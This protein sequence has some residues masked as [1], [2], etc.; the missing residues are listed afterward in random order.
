MQYTTPKGNKMIFVGYDKADK[1]VAKH[2][3][4]GVNVNW[5]GWDMVFFKEDRRAHRSKNGRRHGDAW[6][7]E[8]V[9]SP[10]ANGKWAVSPHLLRGV[11]A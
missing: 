2:Q 10:N 5:R 11:N 7:F 1:F 3:R 9:V 8:T 4:N 6:G